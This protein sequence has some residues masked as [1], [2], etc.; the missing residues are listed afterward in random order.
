MYANIANP[1]KFSNIEDDKISEGKTIK[2][3]DVSDDTDMSR[4]VEKYI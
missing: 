4:L 1:Y 2:V 3:V